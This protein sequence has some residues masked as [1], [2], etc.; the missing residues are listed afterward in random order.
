MADEQQPLLIGSSIAEVEKNNVQQVISQTF[1][2]ISHLAN[3]LP[4]GTYLAFQLLS[5]IFSNSGQCDQIS[6]YLTMSL[7]I[8]CAILCF[9]QSFTDS[10]NDEK[11]NVSYGFATRNGLWIIDGSEVD[12]T[13]EAKEKYG[14]KFIDFA[15]AFMS[16]LVFLSIALFDQNV[17]HCFFP[18]PSA[19]IMHLLTAVP[20][21]IG[22]MCSMFFV[23]FPTTRHGIGFSVSPPP[24]TTSSRTT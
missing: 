13:N 7:L 21:G 6:Q 20:V 1:Q 15:H 9:L 11:G 3:L 24:A 23:T 8:I 17:V 2:S 22:V 12:L 18:T 10:V 16:V 19:E 5:P 14:L 4:T